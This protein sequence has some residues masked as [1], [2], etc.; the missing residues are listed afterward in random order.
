MYQSS[1]RHMPFWF[2]AAIFLTGCS[3]IQH[4]FAATPR[5]IQVVPYAAYQSDP[6]RPAKVEALRQSPDAEM[7]LYEKYKSLTVM[8]A[9]YHG[10]AILIP[11]SWNKYN[12]DRTDLFWAI[13][14]PRARLTDL[15]T[16]WAYRFHPDRVY[17]FFAGIPIFEAQSLT[18]TRGNLEQGYMG[19]G[20][21]VGASTSSPAA[22]GLAWKAKHPNDG[23]L[24]AI[25]EL[26]AAYQ[27][28]VLLHID[29]PR[30][31]PI[32]MLEQAMA[33]HP[34]TLF[35]IAH[36]NAYNSPEN[37]ENLVSRYPNLTIDFFAGFTAYNPDSSNTLAD[38]VPL[39]EKY[40]DHFLVSTDGGYGVGYEHA[41]QAIYELLDLLTPRT[42]CRV[43]YQN[44]EQ[45]MEIQP[46]TEGQVVRFQGLS[47][48]L[49]ESG[50]KKLNKRMANELIFE[51]ENK[52]ALIIVSC[53][54]IGIL[55]VMLGVRVLRGMRDKSRSSRPRDRCCRIETTGTGIEYNGSKDAEADTG[56]V[57]L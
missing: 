4:E 10:T 2:L 19:I 18:I 23:H 34:H 44:L 6:T 35:V 49:G 37:I 1:S 16:W 13:S 8:D 50:T 9:H 24:P 15:L 14:E 21:I 3:A 52:A 48:M 28:P 30:G 11:G 47:R 7:Q 32:Q 38:F 36:A 17:P 39:I 56:R 53:L 42:A 54:L 31:Y 20:E 40:P 26:A 22:L 41:A 57:A 51:L 46:P 33:E 43:A 27:V 29:P 55:L 12:I 25:Y 45:M 5:G